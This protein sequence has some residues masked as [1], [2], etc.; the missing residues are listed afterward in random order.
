M[1]L[2][3][4]QRR[5]LVGRQVISLSIVEVMYILYTEISNIKLLMLLV[6]CTLLKIHKQGFALV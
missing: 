1:R 4:S 6:E 5:I 2:L 3:V